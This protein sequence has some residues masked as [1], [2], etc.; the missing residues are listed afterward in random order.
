MTAPL[1]N[2]CLGSS[3]AQAPSSGWACLC[4]YRLAQGVKH[5]VAFPRTRFLAQ[6]HLVALASWWC[7][8]QHVGQGR[9]GPGQVWSPATCP[10]TRRLHRESSA[11][12]KPRSY[13]LSLPCFQNGLG[14]NPDRAGLQPL[15]PTL[16]SGE[17]HP[18]LLSKS[19]EDL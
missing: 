15:M 16:S 12:P 2:L 10:G 3:E 11:T 7:L 9:A 17:T 8:G 19:A 14:G 18:V 13:S 5:S 6:V 1:S 4:C